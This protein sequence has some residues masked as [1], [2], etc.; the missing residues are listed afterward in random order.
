M[1]A[2]KPRWMRG[3]VGEDG[4]K[5]TR[6]AVFAA[7]L[8]ASTAAVTP[9]SA[10][11]IV[12]NFGGTFS[13]INGGPFADVNAV[14]TGVGDTDSVADLGDNTSAISL[15]SFSA[16]AGGLT[17]NFT[18][19]VSFFVNRGQN[20][21]G[22]INQAYS[23]GFVRFFGSSPTAFTSYDG[24][25]SLANTGAT[26][27]TDGATAAYNTD[28][29]DVLVTG[30]SGLSFSADIASPA[31]EPATWAMMLLGFGVIGYALRRRITVSE[32]NFTHK[33]RAIAAS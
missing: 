19:P 33:V 21:A 4:M 29:G 10:A 1:V 27:Y 7:A 8:V 11:T 31:P 12:Y 22:I 18:T 25:S 32:V 17:Y 3:P 23:T 14:F 15:S 9:A 26:F 13:G 6:K 20:F 2:H 24:V 16:V 5:F 30:A 28:R